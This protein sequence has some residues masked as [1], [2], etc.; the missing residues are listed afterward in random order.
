[1][2][3]ASDNYGLD[4]VVD[5]EANKFLISDTTLR[6][7]I[8]PQVS[9]TNPRL[10]QICGCESCTIL[11][12][13]Q[14]DINISRKN[15]VTE[16]KH[17][18]VGRHTFISIFYTTGDSHYKE[19]VFPDGQLLH[20]TIKDAA[21]CISC[22]PIKPNNIIYMKW[23]LGFFDEFIDYIIP[24]EEVDD[25]PNASLIHFSVYTYQ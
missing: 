17:K 14:I 5:S 25:G 11:K 18:P 3:K 23:A 19:K 1:M 22:T 15:I 2:I 10:R 24:D 9:K 13:M 4:S 7:F 20:V 21:Q 6:S 8:P 16:L 12:D